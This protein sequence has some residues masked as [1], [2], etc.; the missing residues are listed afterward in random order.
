MPLQ[1][2]VLRINAADPIIRRYPN[3]KHWFLAGHSLGGSMAARYAFDHPE[4]TQGLILLAS[5]S[6]RDFSD[7]E[8]SLLSIEASRDGAISKNRLEE[9][10]SLLPSEALIITMEGANHAGF[11]HYGPQKDD[12]EADLS[13]EKQQQKTASFIHSFLEQATLSEDD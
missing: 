5:Y 1:L 10:R 8:I 7:K 4:K 9:S 6:D 12:L 13:R 2:A 11:G 3:T